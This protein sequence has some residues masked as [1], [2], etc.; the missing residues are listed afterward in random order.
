MWNRA[1]N[2]Q[3]NRGALIV[4]YTGHGGPA[5][6]AHEKIVTTNDINS[7]SNKDM[8]PL[9]M[10]ATCEFSRYDEYDA[11]QDLEI[12]SAGEEVL[13]NTKGGG[14]GLFT[15]TRLVYSGPNHV[16]NERFYEVVFEKDENQRNYR[17]GDIIVY[18]KNNTGAG[19]NKRNFTLLGDPSLR[20][21]YPE[22]RVV[23]DS[24]NG[25]AVT[26]LADTLSAF[27]WVTVSGHVET[28]GG[29]LMENFQGEVFP[30]V[31]D[32]E[33]RSKPSPM[34]MLLHGTFWP[35]TASF[36]AEKAS[37]RDG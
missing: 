28:Q 32:K 17:L 7:W 24:I 18:S 34:M 4:N 20:L 14:I 22:H 6:L 5:G 13:L 8:L 16:L 2:D 10:T 15:T 26:E 25:I 30:M 12:T 3:V 1:I 23:T 29:A 37:V 35:E 21:A 9:F 31:F 19:V 11:G 33:E 27:E 36:T